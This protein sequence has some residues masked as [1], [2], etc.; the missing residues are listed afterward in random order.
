MPVGSCGILERYLACLLVPWPL[1]LVL[2]CSAPTLPA[3]GP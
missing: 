3:G 2:L 1:A